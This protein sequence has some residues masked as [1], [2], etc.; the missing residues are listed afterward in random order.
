ML[1]C[2][3]HGQTHGLPGRLWSRGCILFYTKLKLELR[4]CACKLAAN[5]MSLLLSRSNDHRLELML[6]SNET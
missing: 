1:L 3:S 6:Q 2:E 5:P 4:I